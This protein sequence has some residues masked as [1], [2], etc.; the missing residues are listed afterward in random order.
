MS[1]LRFVVGELAIVMVGKGECTKYVGTIAEILEA[2]PFPPNHLFKTTGHHGCGASRD[3]L[4]RTY[5]GLTATTL[6]CG[7]RKIDAA[8]EPASLTRRV[9]L[10]VAA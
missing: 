10:E 2:G 9:D 7:L 4:V 6:D 3:Y 1:G 8:P 5:D